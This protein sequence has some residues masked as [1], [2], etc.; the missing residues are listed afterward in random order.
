VSAEDSLKEIMEITEN[1]YVAALQSEW[2]NLNEL[3]CKQALLIKS[4]TFSSMQENVAMLQ[5]VGDLTKQV[6]E[7]AEIHQ[8]EIGEQLL[9]F[10]KNS[11]AQNAYLQNS[12]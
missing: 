12:K 9:E 3:Q 7:L 11:S 5:K 4:C 6:V 1:M 2:D 8:R 10:K